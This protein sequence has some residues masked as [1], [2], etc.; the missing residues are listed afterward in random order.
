MTSRAPA[1]DTAPTA[2]WEPAELPDGEARR[3]RIGPSELWLARRPHE[4]RLFHRQDDEPLAEALEI[5]RPVDPAE[6]PE[7]AS[8]KRFSFGRS[9]SRVVL[10][11]R[12]A[13]RP[14][15][16]RPQTPLYV[17]P[18]ERVTL[19]VSTPL[20]IAVK[21]GQGAALLAELPSY[22]P[23][24]SWFGSSTTAGELCYAT[25][26]SARLDASELPLRP[27]R[28]VTPM[29]IRNAGQELLP[30]DRLQVPVGYLTLYRTPLG[31]WT[32]SVTLT[33]EESGDLAA[34]KLGK[35]APSQAG[36]GQRLVGP[37]QASEGNV[38]LRAFSRLFRG[39]AS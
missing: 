17:P 39:G 3:W 4:W 34:L 29:H 36:G 18:G 14:M 26:T 15:V 21:A 23:T 2:W 25:R 12:L 5:A 6:L 10:E 11:P 1:P 16:V 20:W 24:D 33:R 35:S 22:R 38:V 19:Y 37:R 32:Q 7:D 8:T 13:D 27:H 31:L 30:L 9:P 28:A